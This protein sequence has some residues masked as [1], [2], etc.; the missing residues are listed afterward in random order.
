[1]PA[2]VQRPK[3]V[4]L[5]GRGFTPEYAR[6]IYKIWYWLTV[7]DLVALGI[8]QGPAVP[9]PRGETMH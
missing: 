2:P 1:M 7:D 8:F 4:E 3:L 6:A 9:C 5:I